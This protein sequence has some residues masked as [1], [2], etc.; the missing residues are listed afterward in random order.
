MVSSPLLHSSAAPHRATAHP[1]GDG[2]VKPTGMASLHAEP[3]SMCPD[4]RPAAL[5]SPPTP[6][7]CGGQHVPDGSLTPCGSGV[8]TPMWLVSLCGH[9]LSPQVD[10]RERGNCQPC[11]PGPELPSKSV[12]VLRSLLT[13]RS[14]KHSCHMGGAHPGHGA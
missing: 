14:G 6:I 4:V 2:Q 8:G 12:K 7:V 13:Q 5:M 1:S 3:M 11:R 9:W 10:L